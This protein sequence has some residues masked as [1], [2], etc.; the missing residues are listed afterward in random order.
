MAATRRRLAQ[1]LL[2]HPRGVQQVVL[3]DGV[4]HAHAAFIEDAE[5]RFARPQI[6]SEGRAQFPLRL[7]QA[8]ELE[9]VHVAQILIDRVF[10]ST[11]AAVRGERIHP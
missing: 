10:L 7:R 11:I 9:L 1:P 3:D 6:A 2:V 5:D 4:V 8:G